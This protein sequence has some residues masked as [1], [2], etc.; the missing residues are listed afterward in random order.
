MPISIFMTDDYLLDSNS[1]SMN[2]NLFHLPLNHR[3][4]IEFKINIRNYILYIDFK[5]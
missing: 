4:R 1:E 5:I 3:C 2:G